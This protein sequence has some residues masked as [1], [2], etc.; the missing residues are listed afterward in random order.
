MKSTIWILVGILFLSACLKQKNELPDTYGNDDLASAVNCTIYKVNSLNPAEGAPVLIDSDWVVAAVVRADDE[1]GNLF[2]QLVLEDSSAGIAIRLDESSL[3]TRFPIGRKVYL[4]LKGL[5]L[6]NNKGTLQLGATAAPDN[7]G[8]LQVSD[9]QAKFI[10]Q[11]LFAA[12]G[13]L[14]IPP[15]IV[16]MNELSSPRKE[17]VNRLIKIEEAELDNPFYD[18]QYAESSFATSIKLKNCSGASIILRTSNYAHFQAFATPVGMGSITAIYTINKGVGQLSIRD[19]SDVQ[20]YKNRCDGSGFQEPVLLS[21][22]S[23]RKMYQMKD[24]VL[25]NYILRGVVTSDAVNKNF[26]TSTIILQDA[27]KAV[28]VYFGSSVAGLPDLGDSIELNISGALLTSYDGA[29]EIKNIRS[30]K[31]TLLAKN[32]TVIPV[33]LTIAALNANFAQYESVLVKIINAKITSTGTFGGGKTL[34]DATGNITLYTSY[35]AVF[36]TTAIP[37]I[38]RTFQGIA[39][40]YNTTKELKIRNPQLDIY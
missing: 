24:T 39:T 8:V 3:Y 28:M 32:R 14:V 16:T 4:K 21:I 23:V 5:Y 12:K 15:L 33:Q 25:G 37:T 20:M 35:S 36:A 6:G 30:S 38:T 19:T 2:N 34:S 10:G 1:S 31:V 13:N 26:G 11:H 29:L 27:Q 40:P 9:I 17:L 22:D 7:D 18:N